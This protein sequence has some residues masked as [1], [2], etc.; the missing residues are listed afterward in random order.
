[1]TL[2][3][4]NNYSDGIAFFRDMHKLVRQSCAELETLLAD[5]ET[6]GVFKSFATRPEWE[7]LF[8]FFTVIAPEHE[9]D[10]ERYLFPLVIAKVPHVGFQQ[11]DAP[12][13]FLIEGHEV[14]ERKLMQ[15]LKDWNVFRTKPPDPAA[16]EESHAKHQAE[17]AA[18]IASGRELALRYREH[19]TIEEQRIYDLADRMLS[20]TEKQ[21]L[22]DLLRAG[23]DNEATTTLLEFDRPQF[24]NPSLNAAESTEAQGNVI[25]N[26][27]EDEEDDDASDGA[28]L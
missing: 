7:D 4:P 3:D 25:F 19:I 27:E 2:P 21:Q 6:S 13:R 1:M 10:E 18:F 24:S 26:F 12:I 9:R 22:I 28:E 23:H 14:I 8:R 11:P 5:A 17:D 20:G 15:L 16:I